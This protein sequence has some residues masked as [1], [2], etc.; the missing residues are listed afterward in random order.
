MQIVEQ[1]NVSF[2]SFKQIKEFIYLNE[3]YLFIQLL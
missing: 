3:I 1:K 2:L